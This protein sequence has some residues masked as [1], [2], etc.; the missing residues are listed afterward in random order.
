MTPDELD[1]REG[2]SACEFV[3]TYHGC[4]LDC[5]PL[6]RALLQFLAQYPPTRERL[7]QAI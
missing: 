4:M 3:L 1:V 7:L 5:H 2:I 6:G